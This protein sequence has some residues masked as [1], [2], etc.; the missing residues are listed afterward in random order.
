MDKIQPIV[1]F[2]TGFAASRTAVCLSAAID[3]FDPTEPYSRLFIFNQKA[4]NLWTFNQH[5]FVVPSVCTWRDPTTPTVRY[6]AAIGE[7]GQFVILAPTIQREEIADSGLH[8][9][10]S[11]GFGYLNGV[12][13]IGDHLYACGYSGQVYRRR[14][15]NDWIHI[16]HGV[17]EPP[18][19]SSARYFM[20]NIDGPHERAIYVVGSEGSRGHPPRADFWDG[21]QWTR[22]TLP[23]PTGRLTHLHVESEERIWICGAKGTLLMGNARDG[24][25]IVGP[26]GDP[27][28]LL[29]VTLFEGKAYVGTNQGLYVLERG[30][31]AT[32][33]RKVRTGLDPDLLDANVVASVDGVLWSMGPKDLARFDGNSWER[34]PHPDNPRP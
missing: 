34:F 6:F 9:E 5:D 18:G 2:R 19:T 10:A 31:R 16:D 25:Q 17:L 27:K 21:Y 3:A 30:S 11:A 33:F 7:D 26:L 8:R 14:G 20:Q 1:T 4:S 13:Q 28:L 24:F 29:S 22:L 23:P 12:K 32:S 15:A